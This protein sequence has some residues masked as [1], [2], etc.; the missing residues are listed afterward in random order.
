MI[1]SSWAL[2]LVLL[3]VN[4]DFG[5][6]KGMLLEHN[7]TLMVGKMRIH[8]KFYAIPQVTSGW[9]LLCAANGLAQSEFGFWKGK[10]GMFPEPNYTLMFGK[11][12][13]SHFFQA[14]HR[15]WLEFSEELS[16]FSQVFLSSCDSTLLKGEV[17]Y[18]QVQ[19]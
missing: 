15:W 16:S 19:E 1:G 11:M 2:L 3:R 6:E 7:Y 14:G 12:Q 8:T 17:D 5:R 9:F 10:R 13:T 4:F 18:C